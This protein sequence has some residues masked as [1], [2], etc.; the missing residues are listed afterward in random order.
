MKMKKSVG[1]YRVRTYARRPKSLKEMIRD[2][3]KQVEESKVWDAEAQ[4][5]VGNC[6]TVENSGL[7]NRAIF[8]VFNPG[9][10]DNQNEREGTEALI[11]KIHIRGLWSQGDESYNRC[12]LILFT[13]RRTADPTWDDILA[14]AN[15]SAGGGTAYDPW[16]F[17]NVLGADAKH[18][19]ILAERSILLY[20]TAMRD[21]ATHATIAK[22]FKINVIFKKPLKM[23]WTEAGQQTNRLMIAL[24]SDSGS[25]IHPNC[26]YMMR[27]RWR[28]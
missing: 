28:G 21:L 23:E 20:P 2:S 14:G 26:R 9:Q 22:A 15:P 16:R 5:D 8:N 24:V 19:R 13:W 7:G 11:D 10:G 4:F 17:L 25:P 18:Y 12:R 3:I 6:E 27:I 1:S